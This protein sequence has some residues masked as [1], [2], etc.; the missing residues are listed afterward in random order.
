MSDPGVNNCKAKKGLL[1][2]RECGAPAVGACGGCGIPICQKH[3]TINT[4]G[5]VSCP[6]C[7]ANDPN[8]VSRGQVGRS[9]RRRSY[10]GHY[11]YSPYYYGH[12]HHYHDRDHS[13]V[14]HS[15][16]VADAG[17]GAGAG[18][19]TDAG[20]GADAGAE[21]DGFDEFDDMES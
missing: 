5:V 7:A 21:L 13:S 4:Q 10:Y 17:A 3:Q 9:R 1:V 18:A 11:G 15:D 6:D 20:V 19:P 12:H 16:N 2:L 14:D 8:V